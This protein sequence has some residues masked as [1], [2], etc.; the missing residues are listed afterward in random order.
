MN[1]P[2]DLEKKCT[3]F[4]QLMAPIMA[5][6]A[7]IEDSRCV[8]HRE[9][10]TFTAF[11]RLLVYY[12]LTPT[13]SGRQL[14]TDVLSAA[15]ALGLAKVSRSTFFDGFNRFPVV[16]FQMLLGTV[17]AA[18]TW[19]P[20][21][22][23]AAL[24]QLYC[25][26]GS[27]FPAL[28]KM[29]WAEYKSKSRA[30]KLHLCFELNR[31]IA[32][33]FLVE[34]GNSSEREALRQI[35]Q[36]G[37]TYIADRGYVCFQLLADIVA[38]GSHFVMRMKSNLVYTVVETLTVELPD[39]VS[40]L[41]TH[42][43]DCRVRLTGADGQ[44]I[45]RLVTFMVG[46]ERYLILTDR[47]QL[48]TFQIIL[49]YAYRWQIELLFRFL[50]RTLTGLHLLSSSK[51]G[52]TIQF[53]MLL[54][55]ALLQLR[56]KQTCVAAVEADR[57]PAGAEPVEV[58][59]SPATDTDTIAGLMVQPEMLRSARG[60]TFLATVGAKLHRYWK[61]GIHWLITLRNLLARPFDMAVIQLLGGT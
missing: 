37:V 4:D 52:V 44:P 36:P 23:M 57:S 42:V 43:T 34:A 21:P 41:F 20:I 18:T 30:V 32:V 7:A 58:A 2:D 60:Q 6:V 31:M 54:T 48:T 56:L 40:H 17:L 38:A 11:V 51:E 8:H 46:S 3:T 61:I 14:L 55:T 47:L 1:E 29:V 26:D 39:A 28:T 33:Q 9:S 50:K 10:L 5:K 59:D 49:L 45:Y 15:P 53:Y 19:R 24:G 27:L 35:L 13:G 25:I 12:F 16:W 22:E